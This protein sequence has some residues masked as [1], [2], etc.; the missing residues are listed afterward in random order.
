MITTVFSSMSNSLLSHL[1]EINA[2]LKIRENIWQLYIVYCTKC[3]ISWR[4]F[5]QRTKPFIYDCRLQQS[6]FSYNFGDSKLQ[7]AGEPHR[8]RMF[9]V[10]ILLQQMYAVRCGPY[11]VPSAR[12]YHVGAHLPSKKR[13]SGLQTLNPTVL[14]I[15]RIKIGTDSHSINKCKCFALNA[16]IVYSIE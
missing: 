8:V 4:N 11:I 1:S 15:I 16:K 13:N 6:F 10:C 5:L 12:L 3:R 9:V 7:Q 14:S 2:K